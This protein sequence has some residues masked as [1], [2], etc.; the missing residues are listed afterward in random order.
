VATI[1]GLELPQDL[2]WGGAPDAPDG[3]WLEP[4]EWRDLSPA[5]AIDLR[6]EH[7]LYG[8]APDR[9]T[10]RVGADQVQRFIPGVLGTDADT[11]ELLWSDVTSRLSFR[12]PLRVGQR[13]LIGFSQF[14]IDRDGTTT[15]YWSLARNNILG[16]DTDR[17]IYVYSRVGDCNYNLSPLDLDQVTVEDALA[18]AQQCSPAQLERGRKV[19]E[20][21]RALDE[22]YVSATVAALG[23]FADVMPRLIPTP[24]PEQNEVV[25][26]GV[27][28][29]PVTGDETKV[30][31]QRFDRATDQ[32]TI[33]QLAPVLGRSA[34]TP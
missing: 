3:R 10:V 27:Y 6:V 20:A 28:V 25:G 13:V 22:T 31:E 26:W 5:L 21:I 29:D 9:L 7:L 14:D 33:I 17:R 11:G 32:S 2:V 30:T 1:E 34:P 4:G 18:V 16:T 19:G 12:G 24:V 23:S 15:S 8:V